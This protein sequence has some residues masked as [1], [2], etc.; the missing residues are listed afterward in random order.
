[1]APL[2]NWGSNNLGQLGIGIPRL[3]VTPLLI[4]PL[5]V[6]AV[7]ASAPSLD[8]LL[9][10]N[11]AHDQ[12][13]LPGCPRETQLVLFDAQG[14]RVCTGQGASL[15]LLGVAPGFYLLRATLPNQ[16]ARTARLVRE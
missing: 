6:T 12:V 1:M 3:T 10:P 4:Y 7:R 9:V 5:L 13:E 8:L 14:R 11:P 2:W 16:P 15:S